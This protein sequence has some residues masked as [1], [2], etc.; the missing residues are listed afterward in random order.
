MIKL[1][2]KIGYGFGDMASSMFWKLFGSYLMI[3]YTDVFGLA[4]AAVGTMFLVTRVWDSF[5]DPIVGVVADRTNT[6]W[7]KFRPYILFLAVPFAIIG[8]ITFTTPDLGTTGKLI[9]AYVTYSLNPW[10]I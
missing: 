6:R 10:C 3:F 8:V 9:Y 4:P 7:G 2:E 1:Q 5:F